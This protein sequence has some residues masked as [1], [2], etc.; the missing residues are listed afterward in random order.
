MSGGY[1][2][3]RLDPENT[4]L[5]V[6]DMQ[7]P[8]SKV[9]R[10][11]D[12][13][14]GAITL[15]AKVSGLLGIPVVGTEQV[16]EKLGRTVQDVDELLGEKMEKSSFDAFRDERIKEKLLGLGRKKVLLTGIETHICVLQT[17]LSAAAHGLEVHL[18][19]DA[20]GS[21]FPE[22]KEVTLARLLQEGIYVTTSESVVYEL[23][24]SSEHPKFRKVVSLVK[25]YRGRRSKGK[26]K[27][28]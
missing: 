21:T 9:I 11:F 1:L 17:A 14:V 5:L 3:G 15:L 25:E 6:I 4:F 27:D 8:F 7:E 16:P 23:L 20:T 22:D 18:V 2:P 26:T 12:S 28:Q 19:S 13:I 10:E 24:G